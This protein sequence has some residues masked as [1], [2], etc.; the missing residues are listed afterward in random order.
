[1]SRLIEVHLTEGRKVRCLWEKS[2]GGLSQIVCPST[3]TRPRAVYL[4][5]DRALVPVAVGDLLISGRQEGPHYSATVEEV[6]ELTVV[7]SEEV[8]AKM[9]IRYAFWRGQWD[10]D[11]PLP[12]LEGPIKT[13]REKI[14]RPGLMW[15]TAPRN[16]DEEMW[17]LGDIPTGWV[18]FGPGS[19]LTSINDININRF[20]PDVPLAVVAARA[21]KRTLEE[22]HALVSSALYAMQKRVGLGN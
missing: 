15:A 1:M 14:T 19:S 9:I 8:W 2:L 6:V 4:G 21:G 11:P 22:A 16:G 10:D 3:G 5:H 13:C 12:L 20:P 7:S 18:P 17:L